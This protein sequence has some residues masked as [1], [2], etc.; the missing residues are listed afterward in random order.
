L[1]DAGHL[2]LVLV[3]P[4]SASQFQVSHWNKM[5][6]VWSFNFVFPCSRLVVQVLPLWKLVWLK[7]R[8]AGTASWSTRLSVTC[9]SN[10]RNWPR[11]VTWIWAALWW[12]CKPHRTRPTHRPT[13]P[14]MEIQ[15]KYFVIARR[16]RFTVYLAIS[17]KWST[18]FRT[19]LTQLLPK[20]NSVFFRGN[21][22]V[23]MA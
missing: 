18:R 16:V 15:I 6:R 20:K 8:K 7:I 12:E 17:Q 9:T 21:I 3:M 5:V 22:L 14:R 2:S 23:W 13:W 10:S 4:G 19:D 1:D 11:R